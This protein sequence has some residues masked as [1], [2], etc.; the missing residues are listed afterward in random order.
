MRGQTVLI[1]GGGVGGV[2]AANALR[3]R[4]DRHH[5]VVVVDREPGFALAASFLWVMNGTRRPE[6]ITR[7]LA[8]LR[9]KGIEVVQGE[10]ER[11]EP[12]AR[13]ATVGGRSLEADHVIVALGAEFTPAAIPGLTRWGHTFCTLDG[14]V[15]LRDA[16][17]AIRW[18]RIVV[19]TAGPAYK[20][21]A[22]PYEAAMLIDALLRRRGVRHAVEIEVHSAEPGPMG[23]AG[24]EASAAV[25]AMVEGKGIGY[26]PAHQIAHAD[27]GVVTFADGTTA[28]CDLLVYVP[29][30]G[31]P[32]ALRDSGLVDA[33]GWVRVDRH[34]LATAVPGV[35]AVGDVALIPL[36]MGKPLPRAGV[37]AHGQADAVARNIAATVKGRLPAARFDGR[38]ACFV[39]TGDGRAGFGSGNFYA[40][41]TPRV[42]M[43][44]PRRLWHVGKVM[45]EKQV[46]RGWL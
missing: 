32:P 11:V 33:S 10:V 5:R 6:Q 21:P 29:P 42:R 1:L 36:S 24:P 2:V 46:M 40:E 18:G 27:D 22:A 3:R 8:G 14:A 15:R 17:A 16:L 9:R 13:R 26:R 41:P 35:Y 31:P 43:R 7:P 19:L 45:F 23:V 37:F 4:L 20:C 30:I 28:A 38:G 34:T 39:E 12:A 44:P 25:R